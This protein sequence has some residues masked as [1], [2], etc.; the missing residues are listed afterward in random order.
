MP[1]PLSLL[2]PLLLLH[3]ACLAQPLPADSLVA[4]NGALYLRLW[5]DAQG[6]PTYTVTHDA[7]RV[8]LVAPSRLGFVFRGGDTLQHGLVLERREQGVY[9]STWTAV[10]SPQRHVRDHH[11]WLRWHLKPPQGLPSSGTLRPADFGLVPPLP[12]AIGSPRPIGHW[13]TP[14][15]GRSFSRWRW[16]RPLNG[17]ARKRSRLCQAHHGSWRYAY[18]KAAGKV[19]I[20]GCSVQVNGDQH[21]HEVERAVGGRGA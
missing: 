14:Q 10:W 13:P 1:R 7:E 16:L 20:E 4:P 8:Q 11:R 15:Q 3:A 19:S 21:H 17:P 12:P 18:L 2:L 6:V 5:L 9:D